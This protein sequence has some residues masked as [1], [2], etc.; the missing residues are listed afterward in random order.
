M[1]I[2]ACR[3]QN[4][5]TA[6]QIFPALKNWADTAFDMD[7]SMIDSMGDMGSMDMGSD[8]LFRGM[9]S[10]LARFSGTSLLELCAEV[11]SCEE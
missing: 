1:L 8:G 7:A 10:A 2:T 4:A 6:S 3:I 9:N 5:E 11:Y